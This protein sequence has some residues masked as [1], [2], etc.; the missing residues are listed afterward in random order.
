MNGPEVFMAYLRYPGKVLS[1]VTFSPYRTAKELSAQPLVRAYLAIT[2]IGAGLS[3]TVAWWRHPG[4]LRERL[5]PGPGAL[6]SQPATYLL[7][8]FPWVA[9]L[10]LAWTDLADRRRPRRLPA[11]PRVAGL[12]GYAAAAAL[13]A[14]T[15]AA[16]PFFS[17]AVRIQHDRGHRLVAGGPYRYVR[18]PGYAAFIALMA[19]SGLALGSTRALAPL[20]A[21]IPILVRRTIIEDQLLRKELG[22]YDEYAGRVPRR[23]IPG[24]W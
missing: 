20:A 8:G 23:L 6:E 11:W 18:H 3:H 2:L 13:I 10:L 19:S 15:I 1:L 22:G 17:S 21:W 24:L 9:H 4:L 16:N 14:W 12:V 5:R 7:Y